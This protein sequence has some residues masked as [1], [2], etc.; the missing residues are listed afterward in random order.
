MRAQLEDGSMRVQLTLSQRG[1]EALRALAGA[2]RA[3]EQPDGRGDTLPCSGHWD[4]W[5]VRVQP[6]R[7]TVWRIEN[8]NKIHLLTKASRITIPE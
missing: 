6:G 4:P 7:S 2:H 8:G 1:H 5:V 3:P